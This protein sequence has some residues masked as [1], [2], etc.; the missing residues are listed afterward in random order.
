[1]PS[2]IF[3]SIHKR[4]FCPLNVIR[5]LGGL[6]LLEEFPSLVFIELYVPALIPSCVLS[7]TDRCRQEVELG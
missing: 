3:Y 4:I 1:M 2:E 5:D 7:H 6:I